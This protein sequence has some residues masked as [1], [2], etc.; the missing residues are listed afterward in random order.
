MLIEVDAEGAGSNALDVLGTDRPLSQGR[1]V[2][3]I[4]E[5]QQKLADTST[6]TKIVAL[7]LLTVGVLIAGVA[8]KNKQSTEIPQTKEEQSTGPKPPASL[9]PQRA[10]DSGPSEAEKE[11]WQKISFYDKDGLRAFIRSFPN[12]RYRKVAEDRI[13]YLEREEMRRKEPE[14]QAP[15]PPQPSSAPMVHFSLSNAAGRKLLLGFYEDGQGQVEPP[16]G[17]Y[18]VFG[19]GAVRNYPVKC[20]PG[21]KI[22]YGAWVEGDPL[23]P[24]WGAGRNGNEA[25][26]DCCL[27]CS[28]NGPQSTRTFNIGNSRV[29]TPT[30]TWKVT[31][32]TSHRISI[33]YFSETRKGKVWRDGENG[34]TLMN[35]ETTHKLNCV[36]GEK[37][38]YGAW[39]QD[40]SSDVRY[41]GVGRTGSRPCT[42]CCTTCNGGVFNIT[43]T[44]Q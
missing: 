15:P 26:T 11:A 1:R 25:C 43:L 5:K 20:R 34:W 33:A 6:T 4:Q 23:S 44:D 42:G 38:C 24:Y 31:D 27:K 3:R 21:A 2:E 12:S 13:D 41:W 14:V 37:I 8:V 18:Y 10:P 39:R 35:V 29:P 7:V 40:D 9:P 17:E 36:A 32:R 28:S 22:C 19:A 30:L 16:A